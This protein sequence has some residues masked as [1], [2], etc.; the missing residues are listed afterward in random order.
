MVVSSRSSAGHAY[1]CPCTVL[2]S[3]RGRPQHSSHLL[4]CRQSG[5]RSSAGGTRAP[6]L[7]SRGTLFRHTS[8]CLKMVL[9]FLQALLVMLGSSKFC[10]SC[11]NGRPCNMLCTYSG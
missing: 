6:P 7:Q 4:G 1:G 9:H 8:C 10:V 3:V 11:I 2:Q 5:G